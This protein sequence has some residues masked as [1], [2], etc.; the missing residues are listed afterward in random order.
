MMPETNIDILL[1][2][3]NGEKFVS[4]LLE[5]LLRQ[6]YKNWRII[7]RD[8]GSTDGTVGILENFETRHPDRLKIVDRSSSN[9]GFVLSFGR[10]LSLSAAQYFMFCSQD[11]V[12]LPEKIE[13]TLAK[14]KWMETEYGI[15]IPLLAHTDLRVVDSELHTISSSFYA[16]L[17]MDPHKDKRLNRLLQQNVVAGCTSMGNSALRTL[18]SPIP[19]NAAVHD[20]WLALV[21][22]TFGRIALLD[23]ATILYRQHGENVYGARPARPLLIRRLMS[24][25]FRIPQLLQNRA[26]YTHIIELQAKALE[27]RFG[28]K[29]PPDQRNLV[30]IFLNLSEQSFFNKRMQRFKYGFITD[31]IIEN[32]SFLIFS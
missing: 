18:A 17:K 2:T 8:D 27:D 9:I 29:I 25:P 5:S 20:W 31:S 24:I 14:M 21:A 13:N 30:Q 1:S 15:N 4:E 26:R 22:V 6:T 28:S 11:D 3:Y 16:Y 7:V 32:A 12:W 10:L 23:Q 19:E